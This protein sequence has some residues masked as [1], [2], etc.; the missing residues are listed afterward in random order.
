LVPVLAAL[1]YAIAVA[2]TRTACAD[3]PPLV[4]AMALNLCLLAMGAAMTA[5]LLMA[6]AQALPRYPFLFGAW[7]AVDTRGWM[8]IAALALLIVAIGVGL[9]AAYQTAPPAVVA[10]FDYAYL[11]FAALWGYVFFSDVPDA[12]TWI[13]MALIVAGGALAA[14]GPDRGPPPV[15]AAAR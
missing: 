10:A 4:L 6:P 11:P 1:L 7:I 9:A 8:L 5:A 12:P 2:M 13:G 14:A 15:L 3:T